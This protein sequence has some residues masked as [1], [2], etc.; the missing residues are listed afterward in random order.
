[1]LANRLSADGHRRVLLIE[2]GMDMPPGASRSPVSMSRAGDGRRLQYQ[3][4]VG[5]S[6]LAARL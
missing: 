1:M 6:W 2:A 4:A 5:Q 3:C